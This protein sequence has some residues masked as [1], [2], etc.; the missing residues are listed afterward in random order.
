MNLMGKFSSYIQLA[1]FFTNSY[2]KFHSTHH[3]D[4]ALFACL[5]PMACLPFFATHWP[6]SVGKAIDTWPRFRL[7][8]IP[9][10]PLALHVAGVAHLLEVDREQIGVVL[11]GTGMGWFGGVTGA[12]DRRRTMG[13][14]DLEPGSG[15]RVEGDRRCKRRMVA[16]GAR[17]GWRRKRGAGEDEVWSGA[18][19]WAHRS[20]RLGLRAVAATGVGVGSGILGTRVSGGSLAF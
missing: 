10:R 18:G 2:G 13:R 1:Y 15:T 19:S 9:T 11:H 8:S 17:G 6:P 14:R 20:W 3:E 5:S 16:G 7:L 4:L 12:N